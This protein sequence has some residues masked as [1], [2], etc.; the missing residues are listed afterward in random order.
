MVCWDLGESHGVLPACS[1]EPGDRTL[2]WTWQNG[3][4][5]YSLYTLIRKITLMTLSFLEIHDWKRLDG[6]ITHV[7]WC[8]F[9]RFLCFHNTIAN[10]GAAKTCYRS[11]SSL[12]PSLA[13]EARGNAGR[14]PDLRNHRPPDSRLGENTIAE[15][16]GTTGLELTVFE[17]LRLIW[18]LCKNAGHVTK[19][20]AHLS[21]LIYLLFFCNCE[22][23]VAEKVSWLLKTLNPQVV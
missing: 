7:T 1:F 3:H 9:L 10:N 13:F 19:G 11:A 14:H 16:A 8:D 21:I 12:G 6:H 5:F 22:V 17:H 2:E 23:F 4:S 15:R 20:E 18:H